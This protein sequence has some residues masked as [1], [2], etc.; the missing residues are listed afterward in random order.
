MDTF[1]PTSTPAV[2]H[3]AQ[4]SDRDMYAEIAHLSN[5][6]NTMARNWEVAKNRSDEYQT[7]IKNV[8]GHIKDMWDMNGEVDD[9]VKYIAEMLDITLTKT[10]NVCF[11]VEFSG[12]VEVPLGMDTDDLESEIDFEYRA[13]YGDAE[14][15][16]ECN[17]INS[18][19]EEQF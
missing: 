19:I 6:L 5:Q 15:D 13:G 12:T 2:E 9:D 8:E 10:M 17:V 3:D 16:L 18:E 4:V 11:T 14:W 7:K 1:F